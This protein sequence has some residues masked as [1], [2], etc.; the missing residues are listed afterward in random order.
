MK[1]FHFPV[2]KHFMFLQCFCIGWL[3]I[4]QAVVDV[5]YCNYYIFCH[6][7]LLTKTT[8]T[9]INMYNEKKVHL[10]FFTGKQQSIV[11]CW[12]SMFFRFKTGSWNSFVCIFETP[13][14]SCCLWLN[15]SFSLYC[16]MRFF[17]IFIV[18]FV[19]LFFSSIRRKT[20]KS[21]IILF[22]SIECSGSRHSAYK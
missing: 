8:A 10:K 14:R 21:K 7:Y 15:C 18:Y 17:F 2:E 5:F 19:A 20:K 11:G 1:Y 6:Y 13:A 16:L 22:H 12:R 3:S 4:W 9:T